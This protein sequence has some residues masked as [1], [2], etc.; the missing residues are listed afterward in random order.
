MDLITA[1]TGSVR[2]I[3]TNTKKQTGD[4]LCGR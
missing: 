1:L 2:E 3:G 4:N